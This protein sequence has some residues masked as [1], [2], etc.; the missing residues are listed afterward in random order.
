MNM[1]SLTGKATVLVAADM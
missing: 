1:H